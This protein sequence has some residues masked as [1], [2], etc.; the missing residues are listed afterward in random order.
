MGNS[1]LEPTGLSSTLKRI[2]YSVSGTYICDGIEHITGY[3]RKN[4]MAIQDMFFKSST[5]LL[6]CWRSG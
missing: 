5:S 1:V 3:S 4:K 6:S 2:R